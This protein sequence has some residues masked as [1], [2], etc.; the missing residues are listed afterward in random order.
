MDSAMGGGMIT[1]KFS[2]AK[3]KASITVSPAGERRIINEPLELKLKEE[4]QGQLSEKSDFIFNGV[5][6]FAVTKISPALVLDILQ[7]IPK[8]YYSNFRMLDPDFTS[9]LQPDFFK[10]ACDLAIEIAE[11][12]GT[13]LVEKAAEIRRRMVTTR[14]QLLSL[15]ERL[16]SEPELAIDLETFPTI[17]DFKKKDVG[18]TRKADVRLIS[19]S[20]P[21]GESTLVDLVSLQQD[22]EPLRTVL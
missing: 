1:I 6:S 12:Y 21:S 7:A 20:T 22:L 5:E 11:D 8:I 18:D 2:R 4:I 10:E 9:E 19:I 13:G 16:R 14:E 15:A 3:A 17:P